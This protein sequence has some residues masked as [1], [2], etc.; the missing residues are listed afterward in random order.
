[1]I[2]RAK[3]KQLNNIASTWKVGVIRLLRAKLTRN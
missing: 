3:L 1:V 2:K